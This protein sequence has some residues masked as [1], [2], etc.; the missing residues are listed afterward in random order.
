LLALSGEGRRFLDLVIDH[1]GTPGDPGFVA[2][3][4][5]LA[6]RHRLRRLLQREGLPSYEIVSAWVRVLYWV[7]EWEFEGVSLCQL[8]LRSGGDPASLYRTVR[9]VTGLGWSEAR[10]CGTALLALRF[11]DH[12]RQA[13]G[14]AYPDVSSDSSAQCR[15]GF[16]PA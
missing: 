9:R 15:E 16:S 13:V 7:A 6:S 8:A 3:T 10:T 12:C 11:R 14:V 4:L 2:A 1:R 5:G